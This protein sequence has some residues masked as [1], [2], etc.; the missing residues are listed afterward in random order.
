MSD[1]LLLN[2]RDRRDRV[3]EF[4]RVIDARALGYCL[5]RCALTIGSDPAAMAI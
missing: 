3:N 1:C 5:P 2:D 4:T